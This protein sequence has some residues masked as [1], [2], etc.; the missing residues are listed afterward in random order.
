MAIGASPVERYA[1]I[2]A[3]RCER[4]PA[5]RSAPWTQLRKM[6]S[7]HRRVIQPGHF[8][9]LFYEPA[10]LQM[11]EVSTEHQWHVAGSNDMNPLPERENVRCPAA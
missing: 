7:V 6:S 11:A 10:P 3:S 5:V 1:L 2:R 4:D 8:A 9:H